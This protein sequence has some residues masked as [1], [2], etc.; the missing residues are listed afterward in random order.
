MDN[1]KK[2]RA[3]SLPI[4][5]STVDGKSVETL[6][7]NINSINASLENF[8]ILNDIRE[9]SM[10]YFTYQPPYSV[11]EFQRTQDLAARIKE[12]NTITPLIV[13]EDIDGFYILE[14][15]HR[16][17]ALCMLKAKAFPALVVKDLDSLKEFSK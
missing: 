13:V 8:E 7:P 6:V 10:D 12:S 3:N 9:L 15:A 1:L 4:A 16:F 5:G 11:T 2:T 17:D 14:G